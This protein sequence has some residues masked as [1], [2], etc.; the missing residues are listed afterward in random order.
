MQVFNLSFYFLLKNSF[1]FPNSAHKNFFIN[2]W[3]GGREIISKK[4]YT[5]L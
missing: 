2:N 3:H 1:I 5:L 4:I